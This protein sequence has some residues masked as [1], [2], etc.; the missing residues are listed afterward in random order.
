MQAVGASEVC[1]VQE[2][3]VEEYEPVEVQ[4]RRV[5]LREQHQHTNAHLKGTVQR[6]PHQLAPLHVS[7]SSLASW[8]QMPL[9]SVRLATDTSVW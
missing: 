6:R 5:S 2:T 7:R 1:A 8:W 4:H 3:M 9:R